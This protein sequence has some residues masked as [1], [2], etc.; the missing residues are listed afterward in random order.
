MRMRLTDPVSREVIY[1]RELPDQYVTANSIEQSNLEINLPIGKAN[2]CDTWFD[3][4]H[5][6]FGD[7]KF[8]QRTTVKAE[9]DTPAIEMHF[10]MEGSSEARFKGHQQVFRFSGGQHNI[11]YY[12]E[13]EGYFTSDRHE[14][15]YKML[16]I[17]FTEEYFKRFVNAE[18]VLTDRFQNAII[19]KTSTMLNPVNMSITVQMSAILQEI[20]HCKRQGVMKRLFFEAR[21]L[22][23]LMLQMEQF[24]SAATNENSPAMKACDVEKLQHA[25]YL[26]EQNV[27]TPLSLAELSRAVGLNDFKLKKGFKLKFGTTVF[28][29]LHELRMQEARRMLQHSLKTIHEISDYCGYA[30]VQHFTTAFRNKFGATPGSFRV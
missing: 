13:F 24:E 2:V 11:C 19:K 23:L 9:C 10:G 15:I 16:E 30:Y 29:Y 6:A 17:H 21:L 1:E 12:P 20:I 27:S 25:R 18:S 22:E 7:I 28:G 5:V 4:V 26:I 3:G 14:E 8:S